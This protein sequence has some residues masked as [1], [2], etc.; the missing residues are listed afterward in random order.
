M[1]LKETTY[2]SEVALQE[3]ITPER[4]YHEINLLRIE[5]HY[6]CFDPK[7]AAR[8]AGRKKYTEQ[9]KN[10]DE[11]LEKPL[12][13]QPDPR[14][15][16]P[17]V[18]AYKV[19][20]AIF[21]KLSGYGYPIPGSVQLSNR[22]LASLIG[23]SSFGGRD[24]NEI[25]QAVMQLRKTDVWCSFKDKESEK[26]RTLT[27]SIIDSIEAEGERGRL[28]G[29]TFYI[30]P[31]LINS[32]N[33]RHFFSLNFRRIQELDPIGIALY[34]H[35]FYHFSNIFS[36]VKKR[37]FDY[38]K[39]YADICANWLG[40][41]K[42]LKYRS[43]ILGE[44]LGRHLDALK[45][46]QLIASYTLEKNANKTGFNIIFEPGEA[47][48][49]DYVAFYGSIFQLELDL[50]ER[51]QTKDASAEPDNVEA[52]DVV[53][54][55]HITRLGRKPKQDS[56]TQKE[57]DFACD[58]LDSYSPDEVY[59][60]VDFAIS[61]AK[62]TNYRVRTFTG[63]QQ[64]VA[65]FDL[66]LEAR[67]ETARKAAEEQLNRQQARLEKLL[68]DAYEKH[69][70][71]A[72]EAYKK[73]LTEAELSEIERVHRKDVEKEFGSMP[74][75]IDTII[76]GRVKKHLSELAGVAPFEEWKKVNA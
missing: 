12:T 8:R 49:L 72:I 64:Y 36:Y 7:E 69:R 4:L 13:I 52:A 10:F 61:E 28:A 24:V 34:K 26:W 17:G 22:E 46:T 27:F 21:Q 56:F 55:F 41:L 67:R 51:G 50:L 65:D 60:F 73:E 14:Y 29:I 63:L 11:V 68:E 16:W 35:V 25:F 62:K 33:K 20:H 31:T 18:L 40:N 15:G 1:S 5:G 66:H 9:I 74:F 37:D 6:F 57:L 45:D 54:R 23:R 42:V 71:S 30:A 58:L 75:A 70:R 43:K 19:L 3:D 38:H 32:I 44:Q 39:D 59:N 2:Q 53:R 48:F 47:F 76:D